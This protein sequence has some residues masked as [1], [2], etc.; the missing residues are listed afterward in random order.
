MKE[1]RQNDAR[2][3]KNMVNSKKIKN[4]KSFGGERLIKSGSGFIIR[5]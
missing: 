1:I 3:E 5:A 4:D 2:K